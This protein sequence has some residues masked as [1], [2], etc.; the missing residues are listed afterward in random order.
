MQR[1][2]APLLV[3]AELVAGVG[4]EDTLFR[5]SDGDL[6]RQLRREATALVD[7]GQLPQ[8]AGGVVAQLP[9]LEAQ[10]PPVRC[11]AAS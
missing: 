7:P 5:E 10:V 4:L 3:Q 6:S 9:F 11:P 1:P 2:G 8:L